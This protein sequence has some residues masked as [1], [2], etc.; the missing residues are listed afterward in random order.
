MQKFIL[1][2]LFSLLFLLP[3][4]THAQDKA[5]GQIFTPPGT[6]FVNK[7][8]KVNEI[9]KQ[10]SMTK[11]NKIGVNEV[12]ISLVHHHYMEPDQ[13][14]IM[15]SLADATSGCF[16]LSPLE[17]EASFIEGNFMDIKVKEYRRTMTKTKDVAFD[18][19]QKIQTVN[20]LVVI[21]AEDLK[22]RG[23]RQIRFSNG[24]VRDSY[25]VKIL[26][27]RIEITPE[28]MAAFKAKGL[29]GENKDRLVHYFNGN[30][31]VALHVPMAA[32][33]DDVAQ[34]VRDLA[35]KRA[36]TPI[37]EQE[38][39]NTSNNDNIFYFEDPNNRVLEKLNA[40]GYVELGSIPVIRPYDGGNGR[41]A[42]PVPLKV[43]ATR[44]GTTL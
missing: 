37:F 16:E 23:I 5:D 27:D 9:L 1:L 10:R 19:N 38:G 22:T 40:D 18:C 15:M 21:S 7:A 39:L 42:L 14:G 29:S 31:I 43:F 8:A 30:G 33:G 24:N 11:N 41:Q 34:A 44:V 28:S 25:N 6:N 26:N 12:Q 17:Y 32:Q 20:G 35:Y 13:F 3:A 2:S 4:P 36:L